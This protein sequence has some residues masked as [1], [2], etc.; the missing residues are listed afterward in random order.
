VNDYISWTDDKLFVETEEKNRKE[1]HSFAK[2]ANISPF[3]V[4]KY[5]EAKR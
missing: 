4:L 3:S 1:R 5:N 2:Q